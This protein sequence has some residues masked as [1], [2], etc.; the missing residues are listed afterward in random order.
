[1]VKIEVQIRVEVPPP[2]AFRFFT[3]LDHLRFISP[4]HRVEWCP[5]IGSVLGPGAESEVRIQQGKHGITVRFKTIRFEPDRLFEDEFSSWPVKGARH[6]LT[7]SSEDGGHATEVANVTTWDPPWY[8]RP[9]IERQLGQQRDFFMERMANAKR[10]IEAVYAQ[11][12]DDAFKEGIF[13]DAA[14]VGADPV[15]PVGPGG[16]ARP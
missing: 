3:N 10:I 14:L 12:A 8:L 1:M 9:M 4:R 2:V 16:P 11:R 7:M 15:V 6:V 13:Q 5:Q